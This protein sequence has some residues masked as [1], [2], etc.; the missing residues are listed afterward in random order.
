MATLGPSDVSLAPNGCV[1]TLATESIE[2]DAMCMEGSVGNSL[3]YKR[4]FI[5]AISVVE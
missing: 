2:I 4:G 3:V 1:K 5:V